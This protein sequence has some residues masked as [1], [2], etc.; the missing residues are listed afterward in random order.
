MQQP[1]PVIEREITLSLLNDKLN[2]II[3]KIQEQD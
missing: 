1:T 2:F 3:S